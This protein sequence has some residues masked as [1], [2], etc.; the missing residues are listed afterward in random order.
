MDFHTPCQFS[1][2]ISS[3]REKLFSS[4]RF[5]LSKEFVYMDFTDQHIFVYPQTEFFS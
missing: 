1:V 3:T 5:L 4:Y 2:Y